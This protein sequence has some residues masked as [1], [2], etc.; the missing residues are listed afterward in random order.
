VVG[1]SRIVLAGEAVEMAVD[2]GGSAIGGFGPEMAYHEWHGGGPEELASLHGGLL[3][4]GRCFSM[5]VDG[6]GTT[7]RASGP[8]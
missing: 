7:P 3:P 1:E 6:S 2:H 4:D 8:G 5:R